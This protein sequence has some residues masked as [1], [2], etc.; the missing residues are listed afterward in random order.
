MPVIQSVK[1]RDNACRPQITV[2]YGPLKI[3]R[4]SIAPTL[5]VLGAVSIGAKSVVLSLMESSKID[6]FTAKRKR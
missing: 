3:S 6:V 4:A 1:I 2:V 5:C